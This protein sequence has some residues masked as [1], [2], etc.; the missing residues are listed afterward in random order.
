MIALKE[1]NLT[2]PDSSSGLAIDSLHMGKGELLYLAG[3]S[4][5]GKST[6]LEFCGGLIPRCSCASVTAD[7]AVVNAESSF[8]VRQNVDSSF[9]YATVADERYHAALEYSHD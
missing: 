2:Y 3:R 6:L 7:N 5:S 8:S 9:F 4:G 1:F